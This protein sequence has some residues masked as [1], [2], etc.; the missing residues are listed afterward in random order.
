ME[1]QWPCPFTVVPLSFNRPSHR[2][3]H[4]PRPPPFQPPTSTI[5]PS[6]RPST[7]VLPAPQ[8]QLAAA[9][10]EGGDGCGR[11]GL[12]A[13]A[14]GLELGGLAPVHSHQL[15][16]SCIGILHRDCSCKPWGGVGLQLQQGFTM[17]IAAVGRDSPVHCLSL[18]LHCFSLALRCLSLAS[19]CL[20]WAFHCLSWASQCLSLAFASRRR[21]WSSCTNGRRSWPRT[22]MPASCSSSP[23]S[24][25]TRHP[26]RPHHQQQG[27]G[28]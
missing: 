2:P 3:F 23:S 15:A 22:R 12:H 4:R 26:R 17:G 5:N 24:R 9:R 6:H 7:A 14:V 1:G 11:G 21:S 20:S 16:C 28:E 18:A 13:R 25:R 27:T 10:V 8:V 19:L